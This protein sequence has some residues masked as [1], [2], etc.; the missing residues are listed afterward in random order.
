MDNISLLSYKMKGIFVTKQQQQ[1]QYIFLGEV[2]D[3]IQCMKEVLYNY[4]VRF[5]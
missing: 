3:N 5:C 1:Q 4:K 2:W